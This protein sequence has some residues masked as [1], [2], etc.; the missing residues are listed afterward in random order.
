MN[1]ADQ[2]WTGEAE[3]LKA[4]VWRDAAFHEECS[5]G[6]VATKR[7]ILDLSEQIHRD[8]SRPILP[9]TSCMARGVGSGGLFS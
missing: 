6:A 1:F 4:L 3:F 7:M 5:H 8:D 2:L 9:S